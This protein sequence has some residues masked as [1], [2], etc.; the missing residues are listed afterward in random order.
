MRKVYDS[1]NSGDGV[2]AAR[3]KQARMD[4]MVRWSGSC[5]AGCCGGGVMRL[6][7]QDKYTPEAVAS[8]ME[9]RVQVPGP[10]LLF[11]TVR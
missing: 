5:C 8:E 6:L 4:I 2:A 10:D 9:K 3:G 7:P 11:P 1:V